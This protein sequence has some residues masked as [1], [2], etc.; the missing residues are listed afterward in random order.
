[1]QDLTQY[2]ARELALHAMNTEP[3]YKVFMQCLP[4]NVF[5]PVKA[6]ATEHY[7]YTDEQLQDLQTMFN[8][9]VNEL[10]TN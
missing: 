2:P 1:M 7:K 3:F 4:L 10:R 6:Y 8:E 9:H 5:A